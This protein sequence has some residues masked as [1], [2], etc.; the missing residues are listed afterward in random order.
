MNYYMRDYYEIV[1]M[2]SNVV[3]P[4]LNE[5]S[6]GILENVEVEL[7]GRKSSLPRDQTKSNVSTRELKEQASSSEKTM[8]RL[9]SCASI[10]RIC[11][12]VGN[13]ARK[14]PSCARIA[15]GMYLRMHM[16]THGISR[17][18]IYSRWSAR[19]RSWTI[20]LYLIM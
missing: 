2:S 6:K 11:A 15:N 20:S 3:G 19:L 16:Y 1:D 12:L 9:A 10:A 18:A 5:T 14:T 17:P 7:I 8:K 4:S 13:I